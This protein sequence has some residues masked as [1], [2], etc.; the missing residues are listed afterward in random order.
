MT[1]IGLISDVHGNL[2]ALDAVLAELEQDDLDGL[3]CLGDVAVGPQP[4][5]ALARVRGLGC[6]VVM[7]NWDAWFLE[8]PP[9]PQDEI[10]LLL[11]E[12]NAF[13]ADQLDDDELSELVDSALHRATRRNG[14]GDVQRDRADAI[15]ELL[16]QRL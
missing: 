14:V 10:G 9:P 11:H 7:G 6:P 16:N 13:W 2:L 4:R 5:E 12:I 1:R 15:P 8:R 3:I